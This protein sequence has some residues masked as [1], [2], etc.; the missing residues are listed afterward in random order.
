MVELLA[1]TNPGILGQTIF[2]A[3]SP[4]FEASGHVG[5][6]HLPSVSGRHRWWSTV[7]QCEMLKRIGSNLL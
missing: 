6:V 2:Q 5:W 1:D 7:K 3:A 4:G